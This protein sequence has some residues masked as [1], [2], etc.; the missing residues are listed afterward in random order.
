VALVH[1]VAHLRA[2][3]YSLLDVQFVTPHLL[4]FGVVE[5]SRREYERR[6]RLALEQTVAW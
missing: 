2:R 6:L 5:I 3:G 4:Q 1:L